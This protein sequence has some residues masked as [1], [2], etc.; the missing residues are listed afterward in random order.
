LKVRKSFQLL[1]IH[2]L[3]LVDIYEQEGTQESIQHAIELCNTLETSMDTIHRKYWIYRR[4]SLPK[5]Q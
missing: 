2:Y 5:I 4:Q 1:L 3:F